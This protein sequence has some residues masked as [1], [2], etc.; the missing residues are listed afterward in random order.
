MFS[1]YHFSDLFV[2]VFSYLRAGLKP[3]GSSYVTLRGVI[4][5]NISVLSFPSSW[6]EIVKIFL[7]YLLH[8]WIKKTSKV[9][10]PFNRSHILFN[11]AKNKVLGTLV[12]HL[13][14]TFVIKDRA[15]ILRINRLQYRYTFLI[16]WFFFSNVGIKTF[17]SWTFKCKWYHEGSPPPPL[18]GLLELLLKNNKLFII[19]QCL[20]G[21][22]KLRACENGWEM[23]TKADIIGSF[24]R[25]RSWI[26]SAWFSIRH[27][28]YFNNCSLALR[29]TCGC[30]IYGSDSGS[31]R[32]R[33]LGWVRHL[34][35]LNNSAPFACL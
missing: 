21:G 24:L 33:G 2:Q 9:V 15:V 16:F 30:V 32:N 7:F 31:T 19:W 35:Y 27:E 10:D 6:I 11:I 13:Y 29:N 22:K 3:R 1:R 17:G 18:F 26:L 5:D 20:G 14:A 23:E 4:L 34:S 12:K 25:P 8:L 28:Q